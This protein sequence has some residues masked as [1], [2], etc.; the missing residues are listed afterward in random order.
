MFMLNEP[1]LVVMDLEKF[2]LNLDHENLEISHK[3]NAFDHKRKVVV[4][5]LA[6]LAS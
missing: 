6:N 4:W 3:S 1:L 5:Q 2:C